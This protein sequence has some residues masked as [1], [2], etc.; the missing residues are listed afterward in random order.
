MNWTIAV[1]EEL[2]NVVASEWTQMQ[3]T[4][5]EGQ[6]SFSRRPS[7]TTA[8]ASCSIEPKKA[9]GLPPEEKPLP[10]SAA[11]L[12]VH[13]PDDAVELFHDFDERVAEIKNVGATQTERQ[14]Q[15]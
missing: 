3:A 7:K 6:R 14:R 13:L 8:A 5:E 11:G 15:R 1:A 9:G 10:R 12:T 2:K 4:E